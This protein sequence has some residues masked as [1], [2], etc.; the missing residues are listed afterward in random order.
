MTRHLSSV[1]SSFPFTLNQSLSIP[2][3]SDGLYSLSLMSFGPSSG[4]HK[5]RRGNFVGLDVLFPGEDYPIIVT[6]RQT[7]DCW[8]LE[9]RGGLFT[10][11]HHMTCLFNRL[12]L[13]LRGN[14]KD[15]P[16]L[17]QLGGHGLISDQQGEGGPGG[18]GRHKACYC[19]KLI[20]LANPTQNVY[21]SDTGN[22]VIIKV[23]LEDKACAPFGWT[24]RY[25]GPGAFSFAVPA[26][27]QVLVFTDHSVI[28]FLKDGSPCHSVILEE[29]VVDAISL[30]DTVFVAEALAIRDF[31]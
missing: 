25:S 17:H 8:L 9:L 27:D 23:S 3:T 18:Q 10:L 20:I 2:V 30:P 19:L 11:T 29:E 13:L 24:G 5:V 4:C 26:P 21:V 14:Q 7:T 22:Q 6:T 1:S 31:Q 28:S 16:L 15:S 12:L